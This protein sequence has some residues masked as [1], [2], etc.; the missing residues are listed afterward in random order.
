VRDLAEGDKV[1]Q[2]DLFWHFAPG[3][4]PHSNAASSS[5]CL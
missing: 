2:L 3:I 1:H 4:T 5:V